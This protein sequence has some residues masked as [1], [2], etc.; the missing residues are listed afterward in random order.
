MCEIAPA[1]QWTIGYYLETSRTESLAP[2]IRTLESAF[3]STSTPLSIVYSTN[4][5][6][7]TTTRYVFV[8]NNSSATGQRTPHLV[9]DDAEGLRV[10][11]HITHNS[12][13]STDSD[14]TG[15]VVPSNC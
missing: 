10:V 5:S 12:T 6:I 7:P 3:T 15:K 4:N 14:S 8:D 13:A 9:Q 11:Q 1:R 2:F